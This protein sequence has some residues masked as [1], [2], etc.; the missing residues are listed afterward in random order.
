LLT[1]RP[2]R[3]ADREVVRRWID[4]PVALGPFPHGAPGHSDEMVARMVSGEPEPNMV[5][6]AVEVDERAIGEVQYRHGAPVFPPG[7]F[8]IG[9]CIWDPADRGKGHGREA[10]RQIVDLL[11]GQEGAR[12]VEAGTDPCNSVERRCLESL[13]F[14]REGV[15]RGFFDA[16]DGGDVV[17]YGL[18]RREWDRTNKN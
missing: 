3:P 5:R 4:D 16:P 2:F 10:Q 1:L 11:F 8:S 12:R 14:E 18:L 13:G 17:M 15:L 9:I 6:L 7:V